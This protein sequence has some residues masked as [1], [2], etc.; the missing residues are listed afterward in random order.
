MHLY[1]L[2]TQ[3]KNIQNKIKLQL[4]NMQ[5]KCSQHLFQSVFQLE[6]VKNKIS[7]NIFQQYQ[8][9][10]TQSI[11][12]VAGTF[13]KVGLVSEKVSTCVCCRTNKVNNQTWR[14]TA[15]LSRCGSS[16]LTRSLLIIDPNTSPFFFSPLH[17]RQAEVTAGL[18]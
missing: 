9:R 3:R 16:F 4:K 7:V 5:S 1:R 14:W 12:N 10:K 11:T 18:C 13:I 15:T 6:Q 17:D 2:K 8:S